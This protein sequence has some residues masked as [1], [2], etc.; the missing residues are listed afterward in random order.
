ML[1][2]QHLGHLPLAGL[3]HQLHADGLEMPWGKAVIL[4]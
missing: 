3:T 2:K 1:L 4:I